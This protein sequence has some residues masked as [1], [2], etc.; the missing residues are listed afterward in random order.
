MTY[1]LSPLKRGALF[2]LGFLGVMGMFIP[3][4]NVYFQQEL[5]FNGRQIGL[6]AMVAPSMMLTVVIP[7]SGLADRRRWRRPILMTALAGFGGMMFVLRLPQTLLF[8]IPTW[9]FTAMFLTPIMT[10]ADSII[11]GMALRHELNYGSMRLWG[12]IGFAAASAACGALWE[13][14]GFGSMFLVVGS[15]LFFVLILASRLEEAPAR[16][17][18]QEHLPIRVIRQDHGLIVL[19]ITTFFVGV[20]FNMSIVFDG[21]YM[22]SLGGGGLLIGLIFSMAGAGELPTMHY[23]NKIVGLLGGPKTFLLAYGL[24]L[25]AYLGYAAAWHPGLLLLTALVKGFGFGLFLANAIPFISSRIP[26]NLSST[27]QSLFSASLFGLAPLL[28]APLGGE[29]YERFGP[30][31]VFLCASLFV[32]GAALIMLFA[33]VRGTFTESH[34]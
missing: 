12:S 16:D 14:L 34:S 10:L 27:V 31:A 28:A 15:A 5:G 8:V 21:I 26:E 6:L 1:L 20:S 24:L 22:S 30:R 3:F 32:M 2:Y 33:V 23:R 7:L 9:L 25:A 11:A 4:L 18:Q 17:E 13:R 19:L 29:I